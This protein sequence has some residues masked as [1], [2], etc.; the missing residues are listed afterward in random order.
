[1][2]KIRHQEVTRFSL[3][4]LGGGVDIGRSSFDLGGDRPRGSVLRS[5]TDRPRAS[6]ECA[7]GR[8][9]ARKHRSTSLQTA[10]E[11]AVT[12]VDGSRGA[13]DVEHLGGADD[14]DVG[15]PGG[16][17]SDCPVP[18]SAARWTMA[19]GATRQSAS[20]SRQATRPAGTAPHAH[21]ASAGEPRSGSA[22]AC[23][24]GPRGR[25][26]RPGHEIAQPMN[27]APPAQGR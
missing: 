25:R 23:C 19:S 5:P 8:R 21:Q 12:F 11:E 27:P 3:A 26:R 14:V 18:V 4:V 9:G 7:R 20:Q 6:R 16:P 1:M 17:V 10:R 22:G 2:S 15:V 24:P 13:R